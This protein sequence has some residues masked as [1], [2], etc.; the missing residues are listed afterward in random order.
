MQGLSDTKLFANAVSLDALAKDR[1][2][3]M[4]KGSLNVTSRLPGWQKLMMKKLA[5]DLD[6]K[7]ER[8][9]S[10]ASMP[11][12]ELWSNFSEQANECREVFAYGKR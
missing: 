1:Y 4:L 7:V 10:A 8:Y 2:E 11:D 12:S 9:I 6:M 3:G 5:Y